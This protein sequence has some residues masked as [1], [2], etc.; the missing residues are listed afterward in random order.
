MSDTD[1]RI[2]AL[3]ARIAVLKAA[4]ETRS[5]ALPAPAGKKSF[6]FLAAL[7]GDDLLAAQTLIEE[8]AR[9]RAQVE[10]LEATIEE[11]DYRIYHLKQNVARLLP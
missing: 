9:L 5:P 4:I 1:S 3:S 2:E 7:D 11:R 10:D 8:N 6:P